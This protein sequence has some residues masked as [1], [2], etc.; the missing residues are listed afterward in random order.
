MKETYKH[1]I[2]IIYGTTWR[3]FHMG[4]V[5]AKTSDIYIF[6]QVISVRPLE[7]P[8]SVNDEA[9]D[10]LERR[11]LEGLETK[12]KHPME[13][14][15]QRKPITDENGSESL[16]DDERYYLEYWQSIDKAVKCFREGREI[17]PGLFTEALGSSVETF[18]ALSGGK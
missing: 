9:L 16:D 17:E 3:V 12:R 14:W 4:A 5:D 13:L 6:M 11:I 18:W 15:R 7:G 1:F 10:D 8:Y 2:G